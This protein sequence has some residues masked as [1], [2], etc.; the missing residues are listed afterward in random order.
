MRVAVAVLIAALVPATGARAATV[1][2][3]SRG[4]DI[5]E[6]RTRRVR[7]SLTRTARRLVARR[8]RVCTTATARSRRTRPP[9]SAVELTVAL[10]LLA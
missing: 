8:H 9:P 7:V 10:T 6:G 3:A 4:S 1:E 5:A 2:L